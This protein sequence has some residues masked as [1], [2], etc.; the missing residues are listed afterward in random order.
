M[1]PLYIGDLKINTPIIQGGMGICVSLSRLASAV[2]N[3]GG[4][5]VIS[6]VGIGMKDPTYKKHYKES[7]KKILREEIR[8]ARS[9]TKGILGVNIMMAVTDFDDL[10]N[11]ALEEGIDVVIIGA[12]LFLKDPKTLPA[13][14]TK[15]IPKVSSA[16]VASIIFKYWSEKFNRIPDAVIVEGPLAGGHIGFT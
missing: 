14:K 5:G 15:F 16:R 4:I 2:A 7:N 9:L 10:L 3:E 6:A 11:I 12:G 13:S 1:N 8:K